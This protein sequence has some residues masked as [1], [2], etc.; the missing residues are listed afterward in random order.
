MTGRLEYV[1]RSVTGYCKH[2]GERLMPAWSRVM[3]A[4]MD[5]YEESLEVFRK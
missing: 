4:K 3:T 2:S 1:G 5:E